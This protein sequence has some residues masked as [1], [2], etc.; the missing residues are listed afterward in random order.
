MT[1]KTSKGWVVFSKDG[2]RLCPP[3]ETRELAEAYADNST[4]KVTEG[5]PYGGKVQ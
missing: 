4:V 1:L 2:K 3:Q 5:G